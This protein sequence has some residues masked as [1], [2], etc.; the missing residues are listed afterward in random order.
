MNYKNSKIITSFLVLTLMLLSGCGGGA[1][2]LGDDYDSL[3]RTTGVRITDQITLIKNA[4]ALVEKA[5]FDSAVVEFNRILNDNPNEQ[6]RYEVIAGL[7][8]ATAKRDS[9]LASL[10]IFEQAW[11]KDNNAK[12]GYAGALIARGTKE[13]LEKVI[14][15]LTSIEP[16][17]E[18]FLWEPRVETGVTNADLHAMLAYAYF[19]RGDLSKATIH[20]D[21][22]K[23][24]NKGNSESVNA[25][26]RVIEDLF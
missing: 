11:E 15:V 13:D 3:G 12:A 25:I 2:G 9:A 5:A 22:A 16:R 4:W 6:Q 18:K 1:G 20:I 19:Y 14:T 10:P 7:G 21:F 17:S 24:Q 26:A 8:F 23:V